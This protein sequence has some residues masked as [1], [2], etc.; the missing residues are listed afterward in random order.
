MLSINQERASHSIVPRH[1]GGHEMDLSGCGLCHLAYFFEALKAFIVSIP[2]KLDMSLPLLGNSPLKADHFLDTPEDGSTNT[3]GS[4][5]SLTYG[6][7]RAGKTFK[8][9]NESLVDLNTT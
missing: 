8:L 6:R 5:Q 2:T 7:Q 4:V 3:T 9:K 1:D